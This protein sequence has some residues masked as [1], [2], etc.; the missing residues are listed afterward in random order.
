[1]YR[2][3]HKRAVRTH[4]ALLTPEHSVQKDPIR[5][6]S[7]LNNGPL[8]DLTATKYELISVYLSDSQSSATFHIFESDVIPYFNPGKENQY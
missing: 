5:L 7:V 1:M 6:K 4:F 8:L 2:F 3:G